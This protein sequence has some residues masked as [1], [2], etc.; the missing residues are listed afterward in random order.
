MDL[1]RVFQ[2][3]D[4]NINTNNYQE[5]FYSSNSN[6][7][8]NNTN[9]K[10]KINKIFN[11]R[12]YIYKINVIIE[13]IDNKKEYTLIGKTSKKLITLDNELINIDSIIDI[14]EKR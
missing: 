9:I 13:T 7:I 11:N 10:D 12:D 1:P 2:N 6:I 8:K 3:K 5:Y 4:I 14:Y